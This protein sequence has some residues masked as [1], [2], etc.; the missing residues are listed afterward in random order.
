M[1]NG[2]GLPT[3]FLIT[4]VWRNFLV[5]CYSEANKD[6]IGGT[7]AIANSGLIWRTQMRIQT[8]CLVPLLVFAVGCATPPG[9]KQALVSLD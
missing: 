1:L 7:R 6:F 8:L 2:S 5:G 4:S 3:P 9:V